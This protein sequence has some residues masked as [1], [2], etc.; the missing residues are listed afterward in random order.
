MSE[1][2]CDANH[3]LGETCIFCA[4][5]NSGVEAGKAGAA[6]ALLATDKEWA[7]KA[8]DWV[9][10]MARSGVV[11]TTDDLIEAVGMPEGHSKAVG[12][13]VRSASVRGIIQSVG[14]TPTTR[15]SSHG[16]LIRQWLGSSWVR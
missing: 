13:I 16:R 4:T 15:K 10:E 1:Q 2:T 9:V 11:F 12:A 7:T 14:A 3:W 8:Y 5:T 6:L